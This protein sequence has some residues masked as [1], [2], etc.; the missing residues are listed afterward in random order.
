MTT[1]KRNVE[2]LSEARNHQMKVTRGF[3]PSQFPGIVLQRLHQTILEVLDTLGINIVYELF[4][5]I[6]EA[7]GELTLK[8]IHTLCELVYIYKKHISVE[9]FRI[10]LRSFH[11]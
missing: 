1:N 2:S 11:R 10:T 8:H 5:N 9:P 4:Q 3:L 7:L 6:T